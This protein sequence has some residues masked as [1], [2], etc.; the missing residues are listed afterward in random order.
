MDAEF[1]R[2]ESRW[3]L[4]GTAQESAHE[5]SPRP[6]TLTLRQSQLL[7]PSLYRPK[8]SEVG[9]GATKAHFWENT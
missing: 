1:D 2:E 7:K 8:E 3:A 6:T 4:Q 9:D 5:A